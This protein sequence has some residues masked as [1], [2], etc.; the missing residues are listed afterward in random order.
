VYSVP[1][2][3]PS[4]DMLVEEFLR[5]ESVFARSPQAEWYQNS[6]HIEGSPTYQHHIQTYGASFRYEQFAEQFNAELR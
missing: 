5:G 4:D 3:A 2:F 1:A 6:L